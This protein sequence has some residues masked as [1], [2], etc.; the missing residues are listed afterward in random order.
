MTTS[1]SAGFSP[2]PWSLLRALHADRDEERRATDELVRRYWPVVHSYLNRAGLPPDRA[3]E[4]TQSF[5][6]EVVVGR[7]LF[8]R[9]EPERGRLRTLLLTALGRY[10]VD[11]FRRVNARVDARAARPDGSLD[12]AGS[13]G[14]PAREFE[15]AWATAQLKEALHRVEVHFVAF[16]KETHWRAFERY[17]LGPATNGLIRPSARELAEELAFRSP[18]SVTAAIQVVRTRVL[19]TLRGVVAE[20]VSDIADLDDEYAHVVKLLKDG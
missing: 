12:L 19:A 15:R 3:E 17:V 1:Q 13:E 4:L 16:G 9:A 10:R 5:F 2:T 11:A 8:H 20:S 14:H 18:A 7:R 6:A